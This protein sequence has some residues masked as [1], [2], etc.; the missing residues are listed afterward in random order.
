MSPYMYTPLWYFGTAVLSIWKKNCRQDGC[1]KTNVHSWDFFF[2]FFCSLINVCDQR[3]QIDDLFIFS[4]VKTWK[5]CWQPCVTV[6][7]TSAFIRCQMAHCSSLYLFNIPRHAW[8]ARS[9][10]TFCLPWVTGPGTA[11]LHQ[12]VWGGPALGCHWGGHQY[13][14]V[15]IHFSL[16]SVHFVCIFLLKCRRSPASTATQPGLYCCLY[17]I[18]CFCICFIPGDLLLSDS[19]I[20]S[21]WVFFDNWVIW[22]NGAIKVFCPKSDHWCYFW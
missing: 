11:A 10:D 14:Q 8:R 5:F 1:I 12:R 13:K 22:C 19:C 2:F 6:P 16:L 20:S 7:L 18:F 3:A 4:G 9:A 21:S 17:F 15:S